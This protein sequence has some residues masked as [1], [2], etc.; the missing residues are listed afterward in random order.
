MKDDVLSGSL[1]SALAGKMATPKQVSQ[2]VHKFKVSTVSQDGK[3]CTIKIGDQ[4][5]TAD[6]AVSVSALDIVQATWK[7][8]RY[9]VI[10]NLSN[11]SV[12]D[13]EYGEVKNIAEEANTLLNGVADAAEQANQ[14]LAE[15]IGYA[16][17]AKST[18]AGMESAATAANTTLEGIYADAESALSSATIARS[19]ATQAI[20]DAAS[21]NAS[22][23]G[24]LNGLNTIE[25]VVGTLN[26][27]GEHGTFTATSDTTPDASKRYYS[28]TGSGTTADPYKYSYVSQSDGMNPYSLGLYEWTGGLDET[29]QNYLAA[30]LTM[31]GDSLWVTADGEGC[32][33]RIK[34]DRLS[35]I[36]TNG[37]EVAYIAVDENNE[38][39]FYMTRSVV[40]K[41]LRFGNWM[42]FGRANSNM[43]LKWVG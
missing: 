14:S 21:A 15:T 1:A 6:L 2:E 24:A 32:H 23:V 25:D 41:D 28:R 22:A 19:A 13:A 5:V 31:A 36:G 8:G 30:H 34:N 27:I 35:F 20:S 26:W 10:A 4:T 43:A 17:S 3:T 16:A 12:N 42:W 7:D 11:P 29:V 38:S 9:T 39:T 18:L 37:Q 33:L 40:V